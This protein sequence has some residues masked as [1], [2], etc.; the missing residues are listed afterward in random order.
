ML[1]TP[2]VVLQISSLAGAGAT[3]ASASIESGVNELLVRLATESVVIAPVEAVTI[4]LN[5]R[6]AETNIG[7]D[8][9]I[10]DDW[11]TPRVVRVTSACWYRDFWP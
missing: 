8:E 3:M 11:D 1:P 6:Q 10:G 9:I 4:T 5:D 2:D 7:A